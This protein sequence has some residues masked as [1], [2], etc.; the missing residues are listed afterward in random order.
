MACPFVLVSHTAEAPSPLVLKAPFE[1]KRRKA[2]RFFRRVRQSIAAHLSRLA[3]HRSALTPRPQS[4]FREEAPQGFA[5]LSPRPPKYSRPFAPSR[6]WQK[7]PRPSPSKHLSR[8]Y[9]AELRA[10]FAMAVKSMAR[11]CVQSRTWQERPRP[12][13]SKPLSRGYDAELRASFAMAG[14]A[15]PAPSYSSRTPQERPRP[16][17][18]KP[19]SRGCDAE[20]RASFAMAVKS[21]ACPFV[22]VSHTTEAPSTPA[23]C[24]FQEEATQ[25]FAASAPKNAKPLSDLRLS[26]RKISAGRAAF[27]RAF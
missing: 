11:P 14:K 16:S 8:G 25:G 18:S 6:I 5:V 24:A 27:N 2:S 22:L 13:S 19:L 12:S 3:H 4:P 17:S 7:R 20:L 26:Q 1:R 15:W 23:Q 21:M 10:S 9:N